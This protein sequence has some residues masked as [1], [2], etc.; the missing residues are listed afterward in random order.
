[1]KLF[2][3]GIGCLVLLVLAMM[4]ASAQAPAD[5]PFSVKREAWSFDRSNIKHYDASE[6]AIEAKKKAGILNNMAGW[7]EYD[8]D[9]PSAGWYELILRGGVPGWP[10]DVFIDGKQLVRQGVALAE[11]K[12]DGNRYKELNVYL[13]QGEHHVRFRRLG[14]PGVLPDGF[15]L[16]TSGGNP[17]GCIYG[18][19]V[20]YNIVRAGE[21]V[22]LKI[23]G[24]AAMATEYEIVS[25]SKIT[26]G[27]TVVGKVSFP[28]SLKPITRTLDIPCPAEGVFA[29]Q[30][31]VAGRM[32][33]PNDLHA[34][35]YAVI[36]TKHADTPKTL[37]KTLVHDIDCVKQTDMG[38]PIKTGEGFWETTEATR[39]S[40]SPAGQYREGGD[41]T[42][43]NLPYPPGA[44]SYRKYNSGFA[45]AIDVPEPQQLYLLEVDYPDDD[46]RTTNVFVVEPEKAMPCQLY[47]GYET[48]DWFELSN[49]M[50]T[51]QV[52]FW[53]RGSKVRA[54]ILSKNPGMRAA[55]AHVRVYKIAG[56]FPAGPD[57]RPDGRLLSHFLEEPTRWLQHGVPSASLDPMSADFVAIERYVRLCRYYGFNAI[58]PT[59][60]IYQGTTYYSDELE[61]WFVQPYDAVRIV[62]LMSEKYG[63]KYVPEL[64]ISGQAWFNTEV[65]DKLVPNKNDLY[66]YSRLGT[67]SMSGGSWFCATW[68]PLHPAI[69]EKYIRIV[70]ELADKVSDSP[71]F[72]GISSRLMSWVWQGWNGLPSL[73]WGYGDWDMTQFTKDTGIVVPGNLTDPGRYE[74][75]FDFLTSNAMRGKWI[76]WRNGRMLDFYRRIRDRIRKNRPDAV[77]YLPYY[78]GAKDGMDL[79]FGSYFQTEKGALLETGLDLDALAK[80]P[81]ISVYPNASYGRRDLGNVIA[82]AAISDSF[83]DPEKKELG[84]SYERAF[85]F[86]NAYFEDQP[87]VHVPALGL[88]E[89]PNAS[90]N[91]GAAEGAGRNTLEKLAYALADQDSGML[92]QGGM[93]YTFGRPDEYREWLAEYE[94]LPKLP[95]TALQEARDPVA[96][97]YRD[98]KDG[99]Y[100]YAVNREPYDITITLSLAK[101]KTLTALGTGQS[102][103]TPNGQLLL[104]LK[105]YQLR[106]FRAEPGT[107]ITGATT[108]TPEERIKIVRDRLAFCQQLANDIT[109]GQ[110]KDDVSADERAAFLKQ[111]QVA[112]TAVEAH[113]WWRARTAL[114]SE[115]TIAIFQ[116]LAIWPDGQLHRRMGI[117]MLHTENSSGVEP[118]AAPML[119]AATLQT[120]LVPGAQ[121]K[122]VEGTDFN[123]TW[124]FAKVLTSDTGVLDFTVQ[125]PVSG[126]YRLSLGHAMH[127]F[128]AMN[129]SINGKNMAV[130]A[131]TKTPGQPE[132]T[133]FPIIELAAGK[134]TLSI[135][136]QGIIGVYGVTL[137][138]IYRSVPS[139]NWATIGPFPSAWYSGAPGSMVKDAMDRVDSPMK[140]LNFAATYPGEGDKPVSWL[141][142][143]EIRGGVPHFD[144]K[145]GV[146]F[147]FRAKV[148]ERAVCYAVT[149][150]TAPEERD[151]EILIGCDWWANGWLNGQQLTSERPEKY[152]KDDGCYF[153]GWRPTAAK[154]H[155]KKGVNTLLVK[156]HGG[157]VANW[158]TCYISD[159]GD[160]TIAPKP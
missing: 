138:P 2:S 14:F 29:L 12:I 6:K 155:L 114:S 37:Q 154:C 25:T 59:E 81:G 52:F 80:E 85:G 48:G 135:R 62:A 5:Q 102:V 30:A 157:T 84:F 63:A 153:N 60:A 18:E 69:Q 43:P 23:T 15:E 113:H 109:N 92:R 152:V 10:R 106:A 77:L 120:L 96:V 7:A 8:V 158:F 82:D 55:A 94:Q 93:G 70:G 137:Q 87:Q 105:S 83:A 39:L 115:P 103:A 68:N 110:R 36:D 125:L 143:T 40:T 88:P 79:T 131:Q 129:V 17:A 148:Q 72:G 95:F 117:G 142:G 3:H 124:L 116:K 34:S 46:R 61:G 121:A 50:Q 73:N 4:V 108:V 19:I 54:A 1:M 122:L 41:N 130:L 139:P 22:K 16:R 140:E 98:N 91:N 66:I 42:D 31:R 97:W 49:K 100:F 151:A 13:T 35:T 107:V 71:A 27:E 123:P 156:S 28:P 119:D 67:N 150:I 111:L 9:M 141:Y 145:A 58:T 20:G 21:T 51:E 149:Y 38:Q 104:T 57:E 33:R 89:L 136:G 75:R 53:A 76:A 44:P 144:E 78:G 90:G 47:G 56:G 134:V 112:W 101:H 118:A 65:V 159:P 146:S 64:H 99:F 24:G 133:V 126:R 45:Y 86:G 132:R 26:P 127:D 160:L 32:L 11:D 147:L 128:G 74:K